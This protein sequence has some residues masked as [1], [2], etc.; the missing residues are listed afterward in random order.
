MWVYVFEGILNVV[1]DCGREHREEHVYFPWVTTRILF[2]HAQTFVHVNFVL[3]RFA[4]ILYSFRESH[5]MFEL[6]VELIKFWGKD[7]SFNTVKK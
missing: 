5:K 7:T 4:L 6:L 3:F 1:Y 2:N